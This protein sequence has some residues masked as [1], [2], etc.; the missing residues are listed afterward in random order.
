MGATLKTRKTNSPAQAGCSPLPFFSFRGLL[1]YPFLHMRFRSKLATGSWL[2]LPLAGLQFAL[3]LV[4]ILFF[5]RHSRSG[6]D[7]WIQILCGLSLVLLFF[8]QYATFWELDA[9]GIRQHRLWVNRRIS[10]QDVTRVVSSWS[11]TYDLKIEYKRHGRRPKVG[12]ILA[13]PRAR[14][15]FLDALRHFAPQAE[16]TDES[17]KKTFDI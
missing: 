13:S 14:D 1:E 7:D 15:Q 12:R 5:P 4:G 8:S 2:F 17:A 3:P 9:G 10:W 16:F 6:F 11:S